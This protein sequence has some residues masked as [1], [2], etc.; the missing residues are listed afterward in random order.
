M[1]KL[2]LSNEELKN[3]IQDY[4]NG[5][6]IGKLEKKYHHDKNTLK[7]VLQEN[8]IKIRNRSEAL[9]CSQ[10]KKE[11]D[12]SRR[13]YKVNDDYFSN[14]NSKMAYVLGFLM[15]DGNV[16]QSSNRIQIILSEEDAD[17]LNMFYEEIG[18]SPV[19]H[20]VVNGGKQKICRWE[21]ISSKIKK[22]LI[23][24][25]VIPNKT[26]H[27]KIPTKLNKEF[28][29]DFIRGYFDGDGSIYKE[30]KSGAIGFEIVSHNTEI[31]EQII[32]YFEE[33]DIPKVRIKE[34]KRCNINYRFRYRKLS[35]KKIYNLL[36]YKDFSLHLPR[37]YNKFTD[38]VLER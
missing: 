26:G 21:C 23:T 13:K 27:A 32:S 20:Y 30:N 16:S 33:N 15:A 14:Q 35:S 8:D 2:V 25:D 29:P 6:S 22:D 4:E 28:Y 10:I 38:I 17:F 3:I 34:D 37:K 36:Y 1:P 7:R 12:N 11:A 19:V 5:V 31:L 9:K 18:G 24:Y